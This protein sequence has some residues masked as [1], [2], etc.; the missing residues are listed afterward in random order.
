MNEHERIKALKRYEILDTPPEREF[1]DIT[2]LAAQI[3]ETPIALITLVDEERQWFKSTVGLELCEM[4]RNISFCAHAVLGGDLFE[5][6]DASKTSG[7]LQT[8]LSPESHTSVSMQAL[9]S[10]RQTAK[11]SEHFASSISLRGSSVKSSVT[12]LSAW[13]LKS[14]DSSKYAMTGCN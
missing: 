2:H 13:L 6:F 12:D 14:Y 3:C 11:I 5:V 8:L 9:L 4:P 1:D 10:S 7:F